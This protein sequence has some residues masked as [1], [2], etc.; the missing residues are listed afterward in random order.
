MNHNIENILNKAAEI[1]PKGGSWITL[2]NIELAI[3]IV[4][5]TIY[6]VIKLA[7]ILTGLYYLYQVTPEL[8]TLLNHLGSK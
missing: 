7:I 4:F 3:K 5:D 2:K 6:E 8:T 1:V